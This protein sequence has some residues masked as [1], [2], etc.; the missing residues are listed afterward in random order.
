[1]KLNSPSSP[2]DPHM[3]CKQI[4]FLAESFAYTHTF[5]DFSWLLPT[6]TYLMF[7]VFC[8]LSRC[9]NMLIEFHTCSSTLKSVPNHCERSF[10][11]LAW[12]FCLGS[13]CNDVLSCEVRSLWSMNRNHA[14]MHSHL[15]H[16]IVSWQRRNTRRRSIGS[17]RPNLHVHACGQTCDKQRTGLI[18]MV[19]N[20]GI[21]ATMNVGSYGILKLHVQRWCTTVQ[22]CTCSVGLSWKRNLILRTHVR[23]SWDLILRSVFEEF[24]FIRIESRPN[25]IHK[26][27]PNSVYFFLA[28]PAQPHPAHFRPTLFG[29]TSPFSHVQF[30]R[31]WKNVDFNADRRKPVNICWPLWI[32][33]K[34]NTCRRLPGLPEEIY[35]SVN[36]Q[37]THTHMHAYIYTC[38]YTGTY[39][40][41]YTY[42]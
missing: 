42:N 29:R 3:L 26:T 9:S 34:I 30:R 17:R 11:F 7:I 39:T 28:P 12:S 21:A 41:P 23:R 5:V 10:G 37:N 32:S 20:S 24:V 27:P 31:I 4:Q 1:M 22:L 18:Q 2:I 16:A 40:W 8:D 13:F 6:I 25:S 35:K 15:S 14:A 19:H 38:T 36:M 33:K